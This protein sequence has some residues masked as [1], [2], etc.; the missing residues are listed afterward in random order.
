MGKPPP[1]DDE[2]SAQGNSEVKVA[3]E[4]MNKGED[5]SKAKLLEQKRAK[6][7]LWPSGG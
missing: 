5:D 4:D 3:S 2:D 7:Q 1:I 6:M